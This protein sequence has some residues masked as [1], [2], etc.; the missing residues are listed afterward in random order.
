MTARKKPKHLPVVT[1]TVTPKVL[2]VQPPFEPSNTD[3]MARLASLSGQLSAHGGNVSN[4]LGLVA[5]LRQQRSMP[6][7]VSLA[8]VLVSILC[9]MTIGAALVSLGR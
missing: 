5:G 2:D 3:I 6:P 9:G 4:L 7:R 1:E 8:W